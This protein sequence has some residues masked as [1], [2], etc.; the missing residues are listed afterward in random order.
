MSRLTKFLKSPRLYFRDARK[1]RERG[2]QGKLPRPLAKYG[3]DHGYDL[4]PVLAAFVNHLCSNGCWIRTIFSTNDSVQRICYKHEDRAHIFAVIRKFKFGDVRVQVSAKARVDDHRSSKIFYF[5]EG[6]NRLGVETFA[7]DPWL[8]DSERIYSHSPNNLVSSVSRLYQERTPLAAGQHFLQGD[9][10]F[11]PSF[12]DSLTIPESASAVR[13]FPIDV[14]FTWVD[15]EDPAWLEK[16]KKHSTSAQ[17]HHEESV[18]EARFRNREELRYALRSIHLFAKF[19]RHIYIVTDNQAPYWL[20]DNHDQI[21]IISHQEIFRDKKSLP[22]FNSHAIEA[23]LHRIPGLS[24]HFLYMNDDVFLWNK[25]TA[26]DFFDFSG[27]VRIFMEDLPNIYGEPLASTPAWRTAALNANKL[28]V[29]RFGSTLYTHHLHTPF[30][31]RKDTMQSLWQE[32]PAALEQTSQARFRS[33]T[34]VSPT[35]FLHPVYAYLSG[36]ATLASIH[37]VRTSLGD[38]TFADV[39]K[40]LMGDTVTKCICIND[41]DSNLGISNNSA[42]TNYMERK[43]SRPAPWETDR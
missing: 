14:V 39:M 43:F 29:E 37:A 32:F 42:F 33:T 26:A 21:T 10:V 31:I 34:D 23:N 22:V 36:Q 4:G 30:A 5:F 40:R 11:D 35:S 8:A 1:L 16:R 17:T 12:A 28:L 41:A 25:C 20:A 9:E 15:G 2:K 13:P 7:L 19:I 18:S 6:E 24:E 27:N 38:R 3:I